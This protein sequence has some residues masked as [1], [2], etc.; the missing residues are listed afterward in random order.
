MSFKDEKNIRKQAIRTKR[1]SV[2]MDLLAKL[3]KALLSQKT[4]RGS[5][6]V[7]TTEQHKGTI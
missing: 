6:A 5:A 3:S 7:I 4:R 1:E 2:V